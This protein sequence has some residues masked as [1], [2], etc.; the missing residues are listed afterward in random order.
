MSVA[1]QKLT[2][3]SEAGLISSLTLLFHCLPFISDETLMNL[4]DDVIIQRILLPAISIVTSHEAHFPSGSRG[5]RLACWRAIDCA[6][7][8]AVR[9]G[10][11]MT[12]QH[13]TQVLQSVFTGFNIHS[14]PSPVANDVTV[15][16]DVRVISGSSSVRSSVSDGTIFRS[17]HASDK[18]HRRQRSDVQTLA[19]YTLSPGTDEGGETPRSHRLMTSRLFVYV[20]ESGVSDRDRLSVARE[21]RETF[22]CEL[23]HASYIGFC[24][25]AGE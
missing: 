11:E 2:S 15:D 8:L 4:L 9:M 23:A 22:S 21:L 25:L 19:S 12:R 20:S 5:R 16:D 13:M 7:V 18:S 6:Q 10:F 14:N 17:R 1:Q 3:R 24:R